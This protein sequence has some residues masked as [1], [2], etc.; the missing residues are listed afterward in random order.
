MK[1]K[2]AAA[3]LALACGAALAQPRIAVTDLAYTQE[4]S[5]YFEAATRQDKGTLNANGT[6]M[7]ATQQ[8]SGTYVA[9]RYSYVEQRELGSFTN[10]VKG[11]LLKGTTFRLV[12]SKTFDAGEPQPSKAEQA[13]NQ[14]Q[15]GRMAKPVRQP[16]VRDIVARIRK[17]EFAGADY[18]L[19]GTLTSLEFRDSLSPLQGTNSASHIFSLD[20]VADFSLI[21]TR[22]QEIKAS[23]SAQGAGS[24]T[25][26]LSTRGDVQPPNRG[27]VIREASRALAANV[28][29][30]FTEQIGMAEPGLARQL[31]PGEAPLNAPVSAPAVAPVKREEVTILR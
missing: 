27:K 13:L 19:F 11:A 28:F 26:L 30:Q 23:F 14:V 3:A 17:G 8:S 9:G 15:T 20:V 12:Q 25:K 29:E 2:I 31:R 4:V 22:T 10:D 6:S 16:Q 5:Q 18:V 7:A 24:D 1:L 21:S